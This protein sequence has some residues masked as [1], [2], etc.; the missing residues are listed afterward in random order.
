M[1]VIEAPT[2][3]ASCISD[4]SIT[5]SASC[6][7]DLTNII[8]FVR[9]GIRRVLAMFILGTVLLFITFNL[10]SFPPFTSNIISLL[11]VSIRESFHSTSLP[12]MVNKS[13]SLESETHFLVYFLL[14]KNFLKKAK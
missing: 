10:A 2:N 14:L 11:T 4:F 9:G 7:D 5:T 1:P 8:C 12:N 3:T 6:I 13:L